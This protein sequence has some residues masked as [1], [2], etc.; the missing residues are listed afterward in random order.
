MLSKWHNALAYHRVREAC[1]AHIINFIHISTK[2]NVSNVL[3]KFLP[4]PVL[5]PLIKPILFWKG[6][7]LVK[8][9]A[10]ADLEINRIDV[11]PPRGVFSTTYLSVMEEMNLDTQYIID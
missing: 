8:E 1:A 3:T 4:Y 5:R 2:Q 10:N 9:S 11:E 7:T 6:D